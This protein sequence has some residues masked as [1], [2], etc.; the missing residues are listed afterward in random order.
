MGMDDTNLL[1][2]CDFEVYG[3]VQGVG[4]TKHCRDNCLNAGIHGWVKNSKKGTIVGKMQGLKPEVDKMVEWLR[5]IGCPGSKIEKCE[6]E[7][8]NTIN[9]VDY[10]DF[11]IRF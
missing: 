1:V 3:H 5:H 4:F 11:E 8:W 2:Q 6:F 9:R 7:N 10:K